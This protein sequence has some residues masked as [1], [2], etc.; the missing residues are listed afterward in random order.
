MEDPADL[1]AEDPAGLVGLDLVEALLSD[2]VGLDLAKPVVPAHLPHSVGQVCLC[3]P[4]L[5][6]LPFLLEVGHSAHCAELGVR[7]AEL[8]V[9]SAELVVRFAELVALGVHSAGRV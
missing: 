8:V 1:L 9:R 4:G 6:E 7:S 2:L 5:E 3:S